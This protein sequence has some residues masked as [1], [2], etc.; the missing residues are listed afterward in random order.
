MPQSA[1]PTAGAAPAWLF[2][3]PRLRIR[4]IQTGDAEAMFAVYGDADAMRWVGDGRPL[5]RDQCDEWVGV[6]LRNYATRGYGMVAIVERESGEVIGFCGLVHPGGQPQAE[7]KYALRRDRWHQGLAT[8]AARA[9]LAWGAAT[10]G[11]LEVIATAAPDNTASHSV[12]L[13]AGLKRGELRQNPDG[14]HTQVFAWTRPA[15]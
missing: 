11:L 8:E 6:T 14:S 1:D 10:W 3:T 13:K 5:N 7:I 4:R 12:L 2:E 9:L 15:D